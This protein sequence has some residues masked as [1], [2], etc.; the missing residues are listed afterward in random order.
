MHCSADLDYEPIWSYCKQWHHY[1]NVF[2]DQN[3]YSRGKR[4]I[5]LTHKLSVDGIKP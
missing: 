1:R 4:L 2:Q 3:L 5:T